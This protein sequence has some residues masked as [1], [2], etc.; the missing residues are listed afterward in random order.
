MRAHIL[1]NWAPGLVIIACTW[2]RRS[3][4]T[5]L[6][7]FVLPQQMFYKVAQKAQLPIWIFHQ[8]FNFHS[9]R[10]AVWRRHVVNHVVCFEIIETN[11]RP[12]WMPL[13]CYCLPVLVRRTFKCRFTESRAW[14]IS[15]QF[16]EGAMTAL[17]FLP[18]RR[19]M[20]ADAVAHIPVFPNKITITTDKLPHEAGAF[21]APGGLRPRGTYPQ[22]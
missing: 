9:S 1:S 13:D 18:W 14:R 11:V 12:Y 16:S 15:T 22:R 19:L 2:V 7:C 3:Y 17:K 5:P 6:V 10:W 4:F 21:G 8:Q 20:S